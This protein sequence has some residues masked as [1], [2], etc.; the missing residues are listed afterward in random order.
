VADRGLTGILLVGGSSTR[1]GSPKALARLGYETLAERA[2]RLLSATCA[3]TIAVGKRA[4][5]LLLPF[6]ILDDQSPVRAPIAGVVAGLR[7][8]RHDVCVVVPV[9]VPLLSVASVE[10]LAAACADAAV[11][12]TG[13]LPATYRKTALAR[14]EDRLRRGDLALR[15]AV[16]ELDARVVAL[17]PWEL[18]NVNEP[19]DLVAVER[20]ARALEAA[21]AVAAR[22]GLDPN[23]PRI[24]QD[25]NDTVVHLA[26]HPLV[27]RVA[28][29]GVRSE[30]RATQ[31]REVAVARHV[32]TRGGPVVA[33]ATHPPPG[34][35]E[36]DGLSL[37]LWE[38]AEVEPRAI[39]PAATGAAL[40][41]LH[42]ALED[43][44]GPLPAL[45]ERLE[46]AH[47]VVSADDRLPALARDR[48]EFL[49]DAFERLRERA[50]VAAAGP[51]RILHGGPHSGNLLPTREGLLWVDLDTVCRG[52][53]EWD[54]A[55]LHEEAAALFPEVD[56]GL[57]PTMRRL[58]GAEVAIWCFAQ[59]GR[60]PEV[61]EAARFHLAR[62]EAGAV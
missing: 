20:R 6:P 3:E 49:R 47:A 26:P 8:A 13:P 22:F 23:R 50:A 62:L 57:L 28:T 7:A 4:D 15:G 17:D 29:S 43:Y 21:V 10:A 11:P 12:E 46:R 36:H 45:D 60:A 19:A 24:L 25:W 58:V 33:P 53:L 61:D 27:A 35:H 42:R 2:W 54:V 5:G 59:Y 55:H 1:F 34:P 56:A 14:L 51:S 40:R 41:A 32:S 39:A 18:A 16:A 9:D 38:Y 30:H 37:T 44:P 31:A 52:P 48:R